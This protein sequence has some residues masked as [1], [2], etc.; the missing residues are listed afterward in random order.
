MI[1]TDTDG[2]MNGFIMTNF[3]GTGTPGVGTG[4][5]KD[6]EPGASRAISL[7]RNERDRNLDIKEKNNITRGL[8]FSNMSNKDNSGTSRTNS[9]TRNR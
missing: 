9:R 5:G 6:K 1:G 7:D 4:I 2:T 8:K 3:S